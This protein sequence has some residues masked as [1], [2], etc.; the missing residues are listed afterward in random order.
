MPVIIFEG[1][2]VTKEQK[3]KLVKEFAEKASE[4]LS[5]PEHAFVTLIKENDYDN[6]GSGTILL[7][8][9]QAK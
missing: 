2:K 7:S 5:I 4:I 9:R 1:P 3:A 8:E 6:V